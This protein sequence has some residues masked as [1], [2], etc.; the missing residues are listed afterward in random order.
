MLP[1]RVAVGCSEPAAVDGFQLF[2]YL[3]RFRGEGRLALERVQ[4]DALEEVTEREVRV[5]GQ[6]LED[7]DRIG[8]IVAG[9]RNITA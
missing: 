5:F 2:D 4:D 7:L 3:P 9:E 1:Q 6:A 8:A